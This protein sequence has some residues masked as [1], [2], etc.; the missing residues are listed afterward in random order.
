VNQRFG[1][2]A[3]YFAGMHGQQ[4]TAHTAIAFNQ[5]PDLNLADA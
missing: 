3:I 4:D 2:H 5:I 1:A